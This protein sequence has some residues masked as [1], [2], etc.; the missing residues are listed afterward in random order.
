MNDHRPTEQSQP[1]SARHVMCVAW[2]LLV[3]VAY[4]AAYGAALI[5][6][7]RGAAERLPFLS[8]ILELLH[9]GA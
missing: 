6:F 2:V 9:L 4:C 1:G 8:R 7:A 5:D 3:C